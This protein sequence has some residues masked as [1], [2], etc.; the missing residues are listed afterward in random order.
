MSFWGGS[1][2]FLSRRKLP[3]PAPHAPAGSQDDTGST[4]VRTTVPSDGNDDVRPTEPA[5][6]SHTEPRPP[7]QTTQTSEQ[8]SGASPGPDWTGPFPDPR[9][10]LRDPERYQI[11]GEHGRGGLGKVSRAHDRDL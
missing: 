6:L 11:L 10:P 1:S 5:L 9:T 8:S 4:I 3:L 7:P 2:R